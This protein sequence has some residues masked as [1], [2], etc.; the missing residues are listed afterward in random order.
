MISLAWLEEV[1]ELSKM[2]LELCFT[3]R[4]VENNAKKVLERLSIP[5]PCP[6]TRSPNLYHVCR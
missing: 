1:G 4:I 6:E 3:C 2:D 5:S